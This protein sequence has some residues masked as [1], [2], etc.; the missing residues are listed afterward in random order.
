MRINSV[1]LTITPVLYIILGSIGIYY[2]EGI[3][4]KICSLSLISAG[5]FI[6]VMKLRCLNCIYLRRNY[7]D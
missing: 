5:I 7:H 4:G 6:K 2:V 3:L 1:L